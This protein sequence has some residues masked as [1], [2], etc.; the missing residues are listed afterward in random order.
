[1]FNIIV[2]LFDGKK[3]QSKIVGSCKGCLSKMS[4]FKFSGSFFLQV[5]TLKYGSCHICLFRVLKMERFTKEQRVIIVK[6]YYK[7]FECYAETGRKL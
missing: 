4:I 3:I 2:D 7:N 6:T 1:M 5:A